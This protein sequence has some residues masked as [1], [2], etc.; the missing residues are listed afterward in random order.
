VSYEDAFEALKN[1]D[2]PT[3]VPLLEKAAR[4]TNYTSDIVNHAYT[5]A[6]HHTGDKPCLADVAFRV[7]NSLLEHDPA[8]AMDYF[9]R[10]L[11]AGLE[12][13]RIRRIGE[14]FEHGLY[15]QECRYAEKRSIA[16]RMSWGACSPANRRRSTSRCLCPA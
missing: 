9:Q 2:F 16:L 12:A 10:A 3:A 13:Q 15:R 7:A 11:V 1:G 14:I 8:S 6:L 4:E 5:L